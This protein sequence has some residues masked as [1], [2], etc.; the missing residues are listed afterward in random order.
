[1]ELKVIFVQCVQRICFVHSQKYC[2]SLKLKVSN[3]LFG[4]GSFKALELPG[5]CISVTDYLINKTESTKKTMQR[6]LENFKASYKIDA[7]ESW[8]KDVHILM[9]LITREWRQKP[10]IRM[11]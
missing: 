1:M 3:F 2:K 9:I 4:R 7:C 8:V 10:S 6:N 11:I 5:F